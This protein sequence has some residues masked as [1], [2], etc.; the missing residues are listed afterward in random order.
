MIVLKIALALVFYVLACLCFGA[1]LR[2]WLLRGKRTRPSPLTG[3]ASSF[4]LGSAILADIWI[5]VALAGKFS[6]PV[7]ISITG[8][9]LLGGAV[10]A[11]RDAVGF[12]R[13]LCALWRDL[14]SDTWGWQG[15]VCLTVLTCLAGI[16]TLARDLGMGWDA[17]AY[18][19]VLP[20]LVAASHRLVPLPRK[21]PFTQLGL[22]GEMHSAALMSL[23]SP[24][25]PVL[26]EWITLL[27]GAL[28]LLAICRRA[29]LGRRGQWI[30]LSVIF[31]SS[32]VTLYI[33]SGNMLFFSVA[34]ALAAAY[35]ALEEDALPLTGLFA[36]T[37]VV[38]KLSYL[39]AFLPAMVLLVVWQ[40]LQGVT[41]RHAFPSRDR[42]A[43]NVGVSLLQFGFWMLVAL[44]P[45]MIK[46]GLLFGKPIAPVGEPF[47]SILGYG[48]PPVMTERLLLTYPLAQAFWTG[49]GGGN[50]S[51]LVLAFMPLGLLLLR[52]RWGRSSTLMAVTL[53]AGVGVAVYAIAYPPGLTPRYIMATLFLFVPLVA[54][55]TEYILRADT[56]P[57]WLAAAVMM[58]IVVTL[59]T[60]ALFFLGDIYSPRNTWLYLTGRIS[61][62]KPAKWDDSC[63]SF[64]ALNQVAEPG[65][66]VL[67]L[68][69]FFYWLRPDLLQC[70]YGLQDERILGS[71]DPESLAS[72]SRSAWRD[73]LE[74]SVLQRGIRYIYID[75]RYYSAAFEGFDLAHPPDWLKVVPLT[76]EADSIKSYRLE[77]NN[78][79]L[80]PSVTCRQV[81]PPAWDVVNR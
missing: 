18:Y 75:N 59:V 65:S 51:P 69:L 47:F 6:P 10:F 53:A 43:R 24:D 58:C 45:Q 21:E 16:T 37:A 11:W 1:L 30:A 27:A 70:Q 71:V 38:A 62:C 76:K 50:L 31:T 4:L 29:G 81:T 5:L 74:R 15:I 8:V 64:T 49:A 34:L 72:R 52:A 78:P 55:G 60:H 61:G 41:I 63:Q 13:Q 42:L 73:L 56:K 33:G 9:I 23:G 22:Q 35:W 26:F 80:Q 20:K 28:M 66:R 79:P 14:R 39:P 77:V 44:L 40:K 7:V 67:V 12:G 19:M 54:G 36:G 48:Y 17:R 25:A 68:G 46:N 32:C 2:R 3:L 57:R